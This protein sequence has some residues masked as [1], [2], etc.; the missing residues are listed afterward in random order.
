ME[1]IMPRRNSRDPE[2]DPA[3]A[4]GETLRRLREAANITTQDAAGKRQLH[5]HQTISR[6]ETGANV[7]DERQLT[8]L[9][10]EYKVSGL[11]RDVVYGSWRL[12]RKAK[13]PITESAA[14]YFANE[15]QALFIRIWAHVQ[16]PGLFQTDG[17]ARAM[18]D[19][20]GI[21]PGVT[22]ER[23]NIRTGRQDVLTRADPPEVIAVIDEAVLYRLIGTPQV[24]AEQI[25]KLL[26]VSERPNVTI[27]VA[28]GRG[29]YWGLSGAF[30]IASGGEIPDTL[31]I[32][33]VDDQTTEDPA[34][35][36]K[37]LILFEKLRNEGLNVEDSRTALMEAREHWH[38]QQQ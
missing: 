25:E 32:L 36:R 17:Y 20:P 28:R 3:A 1:A 14:R 16:V 37:A 5:S 4:F 7:P 33:A 18:H 30:E 29:T 2:T 24:M 27:Q 6:W 12:A 11:L 23:V 21:D 34:K 10:E 9:L 8:G 15:A 22:E 19:L 31:G 35:V 13:G 26:T 38:S